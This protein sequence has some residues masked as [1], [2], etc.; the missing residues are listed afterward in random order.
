MESKISKVDIMLTAEEVTA[1]K[2]VVNL[3]ADIADVK[4]SHPDAEM[5]IDSNVV[6]ILKAIKANSNFLF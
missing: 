1:L 5:A 6:E 4:D 3:L 2:T